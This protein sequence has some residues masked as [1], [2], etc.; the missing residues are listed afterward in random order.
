LMIEPS[1][2]AQFLVPM[3]VSLAFGVVFA[4]FITLILVPTSYLIVDDATRGVRQLLGRPPIE[5]TPDTVE[6]LPST[7]RHAPD[8]VAAEPTPM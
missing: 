8:D 3:A 5:D 2:Q 4:T 1:F 7:P 6:H